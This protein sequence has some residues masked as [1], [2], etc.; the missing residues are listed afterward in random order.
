MKYFRRLP[1]RVN[2]SRQPPYFISFTHKHAA[3]YFSVQISVLVVHEQVFVSE[4]ILNLYVVIIFLYLLLQEEF[5]QDLSLFLRRRGFF[6]RKRRRLFAALLIFLTDFKPNFAFVLIRL[7]FEGQFGQHVR[8]LK[9]AV[10]SGHKE[11]SA[12]SD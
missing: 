4:S 11:K 10:V 5:M 7:A 2:I 6:Q 12:T 8:L 3:E 1:F 9:I